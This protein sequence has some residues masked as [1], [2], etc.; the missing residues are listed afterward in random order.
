MKSSLAGKLESEFE[1]KDL[2]KIEKYDFESGGFLEGDPRRV[3]RFAI[4]FQ[5]F[6]DRILEKVV[7]VIEK[8]KNRDLWYFAILTGKQ[9]QKK[10]YQENPLNFT[11][12]L[13]EEDEEEEIQPV[14][15]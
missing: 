13:E 4:S 14:I 12:N 7:L 2:R 10:G 11:L 3:K 1:L 5:T 9:I 8:E 6:K 15:E